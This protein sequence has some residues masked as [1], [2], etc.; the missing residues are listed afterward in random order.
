[1]KPTA[2][3]KKEYVLRLKKSL[4]GLKQSPRCWNKKFAEELKKLGFEADVNDPC[5]FWIRNGKFQGFLII[6]VDD[7]IFAGNDLKILNRYIKKLKRIFKMKDM[8]EPTKFLGLNVKRDRKNRILTLDQS[9]YCQEILKRF[10]MQDCN[11]TQIPMCPK[12]KKPEKVPEKKKRKKYNKKERR[13]MNR[14]NQTKF[15]GAPFPYREAI[16]SLLYLGNATRPDIMFAINWLSRKQCNPTQADWQAVKQIFRY[17]K[18]TTRLGLKYTG[19][20]KGIVGHSDASFGDC[21][22][23]KKS[24]AGVLVRLNGDLVTW[25]SKRQGTVANSTCEAEYVAI[26][27]CL[28]ESVGVNETVRR[29]TGKRLDP[30]LIYGD[31]TASLKCTN[32]PGS[33]KLKHLTEIKVYTILDY[34]IKN[35]V[36]LEWVESAEQDADILTKALPREAFQ[37][38]RDRL[39]S[40]V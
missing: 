24:T 39:L 25:S 4:Y 30:I 2:E 36:K 37:K 6:Y 12:S 17:L 9:D 5:L 13:R 8:G 31:N 35:K 20:Q 11:S 23:T 29:A 14:L 34:V 22:D 27:S 10:N 1:M 21:D 7:M 32:K 3:E 16:G 26:N 33:P 40:V 15:D 19:T 28:L 18:G 38:L